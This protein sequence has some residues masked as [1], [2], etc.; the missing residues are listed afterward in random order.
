MA[1]NGDCRPLISV[2]MPTHNRADILGR[3]IDSVLNQSYE[4]LE[5]IICNDASTDN[6]IEVVESYINKDHRIILISNLSPQ[7]ACVSR[8]KCI[9]VAK[10]EFITGLDDDDEF[11][12]ERLELF[13]NSHY[14]LSRDLIC[15][16]RYYK[17]ATDVKVGDVFEGDI[18]ISSLGNSNNIGNQLFTKT[19]YLKSI[20]GFDVNFPA[21]QDYDTWFRLVLAY[22]SCYKLS[23]PTYIFYVDEGRQRITTGSKAHAGYQMFVSKHE[24]ILTANNKNNL[25]VQDLINRG[26]DVTIHDIYSHFTKTNAKVYIRAIVKRVG[27]FYALY[28]R[29]SSKNKF[30]K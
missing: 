15:T 5:L 30:L 23:E 18:D 2:Y 20:G 9:E 21:W 13:L 7:G 14:S 25:Y 17:T 29:F 3:A 26:Q 19:E 10:G 24:N 28:K 22:G 12:K 8:N 16:S 1:S 27:I 11:T 6:T 4:N